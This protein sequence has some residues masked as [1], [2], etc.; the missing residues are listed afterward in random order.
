MGNNFRKKANT[1]VDA[2]IVFVLYLAKGYLVQQNS[3]LR[4][5]ICHICKKW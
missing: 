5:I 1:I 2:S 3:G 4:A